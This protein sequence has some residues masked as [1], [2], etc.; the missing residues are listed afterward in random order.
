M[1][2]QKIVDIL[3]TD[4]TKAKEEHT[5]LNSVIK[6]REKSEDELR[7]ELKKQKEEYTKLDMRLSALK[8]EY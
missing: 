7:D 4:L 8:K 3:Q 6:T 2:N 5:R 1:R